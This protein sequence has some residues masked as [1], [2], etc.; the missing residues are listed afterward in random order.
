MTTGSIGRGLLR[1]AGVL[2]LAGLT[3]SC[4]SPQQSAMVAPAGFGKDPVSRAER[5][6]SYCDRLA[7]KGELVTALGLCAR[8]HEIN[9]DAPEALVKIAGILHKMG[10]KQAAVQTYVAL[11]EQFP[12]HHEARYSLGKLYMEMGDTTMAAGEFNIAMRDNPKDPR[13][14][15]AM[16]I[17]RDQAGEHQ[18]AQALYRKALERDPENRSLRN[19]LG[20]S[21][22]LSG[23]RDAAI[24]VLAELAVDPEAHQTV[25]RNLEAA[26]AAR[27][28]PAPAGAA[29]P[30]ALDAEEAAPLGAPENGPMVQPVKTEVLAPAEGM[31]PSVPRK[32]APSPAAGGAPMPLYVPQPSTAGEPHQSGARTAEPSSTILAA[33]ERLMAPP[34]WADFEP[35]ALLGRVPAPSAP[36]A[37][38]PSADT[39]SATEPPGGA[40]AEAEVPPQNG[41]LGEIS[42]DPMDLGSSAQP[43]ANN[44]SLL[45]VD[46]N[47]D[48]V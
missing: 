38:I 31:E 12:R 18:A 42:V 16:G 37:N 7:D 8:A 25:L 33:A 1:L 20:L 17:L 6:V 27:S 21:L 2:V 3:V 39:P 19:N 32:A 15:N 30:A 45:L 46:G 11:L 44:L 10:R 43:R 5:L 9:P 14:Y 29:T 47:S 13:P 36:S 22:A 24:E 23:Q 35:G 40:P 41:E 4:A 26:Y 48:S 28:V 34:E